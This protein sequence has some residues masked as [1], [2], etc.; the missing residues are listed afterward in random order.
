MSAHFFLL[1]V[2]E[3]YKA[4]CSITG[5]SLLKLAAYQLAHCSMIKFILPVVSCTQVRKRWFILTQCKYH[6]AWFTL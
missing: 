2:D 4:Q 6:K 5:F 1:I 3:T